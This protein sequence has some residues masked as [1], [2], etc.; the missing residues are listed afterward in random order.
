MAYTRT[1]TVDAAPSGDTVK[2]A[3]LDVDTDLTGVFANLNTHEA[4]TVG[5]H[6]VASGT[7]VGTA[8]TDTLTNKTISGATLTGTI[9]ASSATITGGTSVNMTL[10][11]PTLTGTV[12][13]SGATLVSPT[14]T[15]ATIQSSTINGLTHT[16]STTGFTIAGGTASKTL[17]VTD[18]L[19]TPTVTVGDTLYGSAAG[20]LSSLAKGT[21]NYKMFMNAGATAPEWASGFKIGTFTRDLTTASGDVAVTG[22]GFKPSAILIFAVGTASYGFCVGGFIAG[23]SGGQG[24]CIYEADK[25]TSVMRIYGPTVDHYNT[26]SLTSVDTD[27]F[28]LYFTK[29]TTPTGTGYIQYL[30]LR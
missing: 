24:I 7:I 19:S 22:V 27:G 29:T 15:N 11:T 25:M 30:A 28:T 6:G 10:Q 3:V 12:T 14:I 18:T 2:Q 8:T 17:T 26:L 20:V 1:T 4:L 23:T 9:T 5:A 13:A 21:A 16:A